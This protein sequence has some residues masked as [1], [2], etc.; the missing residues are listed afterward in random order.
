[1]TTEVQYKAVSGL[2]H[3]ISDVG[4]FVAAV[5]NLP[6][7]PP[8]KQ[9]KLAAVIKR[10]Y[11]QIGSI[12]EGADTILNS[13]CCLRRLQ[14]IIWQ[15]VFTSCRQRHFTGMHH[16]HTVSCRPA[17]L[18]AQVAF[19]CQWMKRQRQPKALHSLSS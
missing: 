5:D 18:Y 13:S 6:Q 7:V 1:M 2:G 17:L 8:E 10:L 14:H 16:I 4:H 15:Q 11:A 19:G 12:R 9:E 3:C